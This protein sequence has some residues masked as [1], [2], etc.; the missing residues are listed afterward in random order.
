[1]K[2][3]FL[4]AFVFLVAFYNAK[5]QSCVPTTINGSV[6]NLACGQAC[7]PFM[8]QVPHL[9]ATTDYIL[10]PIDYAPLAYT[11]G[12]EDPSLYDDD[13]YSFLINLPFT[14][15]FYGANYTS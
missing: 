2:K 10:S 3:N 12:S 15:C 6:V 9:K 4:L 5:T 7:T 13:Q 8:Y 1:M 11:G 14:F